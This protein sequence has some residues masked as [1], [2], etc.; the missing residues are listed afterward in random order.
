MMYSLIL[1][2]VLLAQIPIFTAAGAGAQADNPPPAATQP[3]TLGATQSAG[4]ASPDDPQPRGLLDSFSRSRLGQIAQGK[5]A[6]TWESLQEMREPGFWLDS[7]KSLVLA[8]LMLV[9]RMLIA[10]LF[11]VIFYFLYRGIRKLVLSSL[12]KANVDASIRDMLS[13]LIKWGVMGFGLI[14][15]CNQIGIQITALLAGVSVVGL[16][17]GFAAQETLANFIAGIV[18]FWD[19]PFAVGDWVTVHDTFA[20]VKRVTFRSTR[21]LTGNGEM[22]VLP[23]TSVLANKLVN[24]S[25]HPLQRV[26]IPIGIAYKESIADARDVLLSITRDDQRIL[27]DPAPIVTISECADSSIN[28]VLRFWINDESAE[29]IMRSEYLEKAKNAFD[30]AG[31]SIPFPHMQVLLEETAALKSVVHHRAA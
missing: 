20:Q 14:I 18:I 5:R 27:A 8:L 11:L 12:G 28:L 22:M 25:T 26:N 2:L 3:T 15:A 13:S 29:W 19:K 1:R 16:A 24:H 4:T 23:N 7:I 21:L 10:A 6:V 9:P 30:R 17:I 31:I